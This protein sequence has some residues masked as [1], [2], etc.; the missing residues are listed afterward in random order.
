MEHKI[1]SQIG[2][3]STDYGSPLSDVEMRLLMQEPI[4]ETEALREAGN[5]RLQPRD[6][7]DDDDH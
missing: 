7:S 5:T 1:Y 2:K 6:E 4:R 3:S